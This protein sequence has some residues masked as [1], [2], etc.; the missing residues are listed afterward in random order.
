MNHQSQTRIIKDDSHFKSQIWIIEHHLHFK[1][2]TG[3]SK[4]THILKAKF[5]PLKTTQLKTTHTIPKPNVTH[6]KPPVFEKSHA[7][8]MRSSMF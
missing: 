2:R 6:Q 7:D 3:S 1:N 4:T 5:G 8:H